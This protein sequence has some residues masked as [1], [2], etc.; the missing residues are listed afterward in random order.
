MVLGISRSHKITKKYF[1][2]QG[3]LRKHVQTQ[4]Y[5]VLSIYL[6]GRI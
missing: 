5:Q 4:N 2:V 1:S 3:Y 6:S